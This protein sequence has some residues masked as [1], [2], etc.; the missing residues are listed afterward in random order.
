MTPLR[1]ARHPA[2]VARAL[3]AGL[4]VAAALGVVAVMARDSQHRTAPSSTAR[5]VEVRIGED[6]S[7]AEARA[8]LRSWLEGQPDL[9][10]DGSLTV[11]D[12]PPDTTTA[13]S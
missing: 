8:A 13:P 2:F 5:T 12:S 3:T 1:R 10:R 6:V 4:S 9:D 7:D 11:V